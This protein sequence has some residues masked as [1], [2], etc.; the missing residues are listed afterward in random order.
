MFTKAFLKLTLQ[1]SNSLVV[2]GVKISNFCLVKFTYF[3]SR[4]VSSLSSL[5]KGTPFSPRWDGVP[6]HVGVVAKLGISYQPTGHKG[7]SDRGESQTRP[8]NIGG[9]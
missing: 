4:V 7:R 5:T 2:F 9:V 8:L 1:P 3:G 6:W